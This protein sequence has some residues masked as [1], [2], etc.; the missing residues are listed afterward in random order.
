MGKLSESDDLQGFFLFAL[1]YRKIIL[2]WED[3]LKPHTTEGFMVMEE[4]MKNRIYFILVMSNISEGS[5]SLR[6]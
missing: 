3:K 1:I 4:K 5:S 2:A 6:Y